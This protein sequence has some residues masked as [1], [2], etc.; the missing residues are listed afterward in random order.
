MDG[1]EAQKVY[2]SRALAAS[3]CGGE[4]D[5][6]DEMA[7]TY[8]GTMNVELYN[9]RVSYVNYIQCISVHVYI[10]Y[11][12]IIPDLPTKNRYVENHGWEAHQ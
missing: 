12:Y 3:G 10:L 2:V 9:F 6:R 5:V 1:I 7:Q 4:M 11:I 8:L